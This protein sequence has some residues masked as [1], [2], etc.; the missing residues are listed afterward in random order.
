MASRPFLSTARLERGCRCD[1]LGQHQEQDMK[2]PLNFLLYISNSPCHWVRERSYWRRGRIKKITAPPSWHR[3][4]LSKSHCTWF[5]AL[6]FCTCYNL[7]RDTKLCISQSWVSQCLP[8]NRVFAGLWL[9]FQRHLGADKARGIAWS[10]CHRWLDIIMIIKISK[11][12]KINN[13]HVY[14]VFCQIFSHDHDLWGSWWIGAGIS[15]WSYF[16]D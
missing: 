8:F 7:W 16:P 2:V 3:C 11:N 15:Q 5:F 14:Q 9:Q 4:I 6:D 10:C 1:K 13:N 12:N